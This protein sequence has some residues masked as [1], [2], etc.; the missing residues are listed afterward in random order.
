MYVCVYI[1]IY[2]HT[3]THI[4]LVPEKVVSLWSDITWIIVLL[5][6]SLSWS[7]VYPRPIRRGETQNCH[8]HPRPHPSIIYDF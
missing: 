5:F 2:T 3:H 6:F 4:L 1:Y 8:L 7:L